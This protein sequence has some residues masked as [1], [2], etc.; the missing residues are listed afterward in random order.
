MR[1]IFCSM[2]ASTNEEYKA[3]IKNRMKLFALMGAAGAITVIVALLAAFR[4]RTAIKEEMLSMYTGFGTGLLIISVILWILHRVTLN[5]EE[6]LKESRIKNSDERLLD[7]SNRAFRFAGGVML[8]VMYGIALIGGLFF[9][10][11]VK[12]LL[13]L[14]CV[15]L[16]SYL[17]A[18][19][20]YLR[21]M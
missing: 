4:W 14:M 6:K 8:A 21:R 13:A 1:G 9:P 10:V 11:L 5:S 18:Y 2:A 15:F 3:I 12:M 7:I 20:Y 16:A 17:A 19:W